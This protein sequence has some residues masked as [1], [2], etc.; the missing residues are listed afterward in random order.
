MEYFPN[1]K[2]TYAHFVDNFSNRLNF[3]RIQS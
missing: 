2:K 3:N 1:M